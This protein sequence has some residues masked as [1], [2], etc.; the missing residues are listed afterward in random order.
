MNA[1]QTTHENHLCDKES[2]WFAVHTRFKSEKMALKFLSSNEVNAYLPVKNMSRKYGNRVRAIEMP[3][4]SSCIFVRIKKSEY[5]KVLETPYTAGFFKIGKNLLSVKDK[6]IELIQKLIGEN[7]DVEVERKEYL[8]GDIVEISAGPL[9]GLQ[10]KL[11][12]FNG[13]QKVAVELINSEF[14]LKISIELSLLK[15]IG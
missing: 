3:L 5:I 11:I 7:I 10:G 14:Y 13:K 1:T 8:S 6:E 9:M 12:T 15:K 4:I 2:K